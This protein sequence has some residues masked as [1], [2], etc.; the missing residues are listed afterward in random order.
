MPRP[1]KHR[2]VRGFTLVELLTTMTIIG[3]LA[4]VSGPRFFSTP[5]FAARGFADDL[6]GALRYAQHLAIA[7]GC[8]VQ[9]TIDTGGY[10]VMRFGGGDCNDRT[11]PLSAVHRS[12][13]DELRAA[14][15]DGIS[16]R[17]AEFYF[18]TLGRP[19]SASS[20]RLIDSD[21]ELAFDTVRVRVHAESGLVE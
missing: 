13:G 21:I 3:V 4:A 8:G 14:L 20:G 6:R 5:A 17:S 2:L 15:P 9:V 11:G 19:R 16:G 1:A 10:Q 7:S 12:G 18:D